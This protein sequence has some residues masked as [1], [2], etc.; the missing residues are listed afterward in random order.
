MDTDAKSLHK[1]AEDAR[2]EERFLDALEFCD[3]AMLAFQKEE[4]ALGFTEV[5]SSRFLTLRHL[6]EQTQD[7]NFMIL[8]KHTIMAAVE[9]ARNSGDLEALAIPL[10]NL[11]KA[12]QTLKEYDLAVNS[13]KEAISNM[14]KNPPKEHNRSSVIAEMNIHLSVCEYKNGDKSAL[15][16]TEKALVDLA[17]DKEDK[18]SKDVWMS[19][20]Y[21]DI[22]EM[23]KDTDPNKA[24]QALNRAKEIIDSNPKL[25]LRKKQFEKLSASF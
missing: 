21:M 16:R 7:K 1:K 22:A 14:I 8:A 13:F 18:Y 15:K 2:E 11:G 23:I 9:I 5:L 6:F 3:K 20:G 10:F 4:D 24:K 25:T 12:Y 19:G 17:S